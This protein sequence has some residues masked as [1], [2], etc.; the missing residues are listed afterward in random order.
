MYVIACCTCRGVGSCNLV[1]VSEPYGTSSR[2]QW[3]NRAVLGVSAVK[4]LSG[5]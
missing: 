3:P 1:V 2:P 4:Y 5:T